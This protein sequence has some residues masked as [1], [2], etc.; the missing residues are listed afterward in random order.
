MHEVCLLANKLTQTNSTRWTCI[1]FMLGC[2]GNL[3]LQQVIWHYISKQCIHEQC[4][5]KIEAT[6]PQVLRSKFSLC[7]FWIFY[8]LN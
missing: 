4:T 8:I 5:V 3:Q 6:Q 1:Q 2:R 7:V